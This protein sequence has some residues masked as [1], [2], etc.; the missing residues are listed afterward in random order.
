MS[1]TIHIYRVKFDSGS[2]GYTTSEDGYENLAAV[3]GEERI[4]IAHWQ[5]GREL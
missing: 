4:T 1:E 5:A 3:E 2:Y